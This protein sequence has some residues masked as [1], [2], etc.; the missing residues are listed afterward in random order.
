MSKGKFIESTFLDAR[1]NQ[2]NGVVQEKDFTD[3][4]ENSY[5]FGQF[6]AY[7][8]ALSLIEKKGVEACQAFMRKKLSEIAKG[9]PAF[10]VKAEELEKSLMQYYR[11]SME[12]NDTHVKEQKNV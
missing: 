12:S 9:N 4:I 3:A 1:G 8:F 10:I 7:Y 11:D 2:I 5:F 6:M